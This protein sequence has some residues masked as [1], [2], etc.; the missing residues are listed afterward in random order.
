MVSPKTNV[1]DLMF[2]YSIYKTI[3]SFPNPFVVGFLSIFPFW[4]YVHHIS[5]RFLFHELSHAYKLRYKYFSK[6]EN[7]CFKRFVEKLEE[8][9]LDSKIGPL[10]RELALIPYPPPILYGRI[11][12]NEQ[13]L[14]EKL[15]REDEVLLCSFIDHQ[16]YSG[17]FSAGCSTTRSGRSALTALTSQ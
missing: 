9:S 3:T 13:H 4:L 16:I 10:R 11:V 6:E 2:A 8:S 5:K 14:E 15:A 7:S 12:K 17:K 1:V